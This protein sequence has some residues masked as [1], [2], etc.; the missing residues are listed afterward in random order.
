MN[1]KTRNKTQHEKH[2]KNL[3]AKFRALRAFVILHTSPQQ[4]KST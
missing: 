2:E 3:N 4:R 1:T